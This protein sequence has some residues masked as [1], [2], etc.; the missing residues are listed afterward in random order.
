MLKLIPI[1]LFS[2]D[3]KLV[4]GDRTLAL[5]DSSWFREK[6]QFGVGGR[7][8][9]VGRTGLMSVEFYLKENATV[10]ARARKPSALMRSFQV[11]V[12]GSEY[13]FEAASI[14]SRTFVLLQDTR[15]VGSIRPAGIF[16]RKALVSLPESLPL[17][18]R[19]FMAWLVIVMWKRQQ[20]SS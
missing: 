5:I 18:V 16:T 20:N 7:R 13:R 3:F 6:G 1:G 9:E 10:L 11:R 4:D 17:E 19:V 14:F 15:K 8:F 12:N 2:W